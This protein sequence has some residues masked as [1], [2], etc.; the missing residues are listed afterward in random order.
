MNFGQKKK[1][2]LIRVN[3]ITEIEVYYEPC[4]LPRQSAAAKLQL[5]KLNLASPCKSGASASHEKGTNV[6]NS[7]KK[8]L[9]QRFSARL[10][11]VLLLTSSPGT[12]GI[13]WRHFWSSQLGGCYWHLVCIDQRCCLISCSAQDRPHPSPQQKRLRSQESRVVRLRNLESN[14]YCA[15]LSRSGVV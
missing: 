9:D 2:S 15:V 4:K 8:G 5:P 12:S 13:V 10:G 1:K 7:N 3:L 11:A 6:H 14:M